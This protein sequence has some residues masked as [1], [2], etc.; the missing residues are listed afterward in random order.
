AQIEQLE[1]GIARASCLLSPQGRILFD[2]LVLRTA[3]AVYL[4]TEAQQAEPLIKRLSLYRLRRAIE[5]TH[6]PEFQVGHLANFDQPDQIEASTLPEKA[7]SAI[8]ERHP[9]LG[10]LWLINQQDIPCGKPD[11]E[12]QKWRICSGI[13]EGAADLT[14]NRA[15]MLEAGLDKLAAVDFKKGCYIGQEVTARTHYRGLVKRRLF[16]VS[17]PKGRLSVGASVGL[18]DKIIGQCGSVASDGQT[19]Y[20]LASLRLDAVQQAEKQTGQENSAFQ[21]EDGT[22]LQLVIPGWMHPLP[23]FDSTDE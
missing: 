16:P 22:P 17:A 5:I 19:D 8:D 13:P 2:M 23:G 15:L 1:Q 6:R 18:A 11:E 21:L 4:V 12:W 20:A 10:W 14:P 3:E 9:H 7:I